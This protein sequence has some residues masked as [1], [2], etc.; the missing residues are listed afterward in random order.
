MICPHCGFNSKDGAVF[1]DKCGK[2]MPNISDLFSGP[3]KSSEINQQSAT[4]NNTDVTKPNANFSPIINNNSTQ[5]SF[6]KSNLDSSTTISKSSAS[7]A[8]SST[9]N[10]N[11]NNKSLPKDEIKSDTKPS[12]FDSVIENANTVAGDTAKIHGKDITKKTEININ[13]NKGSDKKNKSLIGFSKVISTPEF[14]SKL[15]QYNLKNLM[16]GLFIIP[17]PLILLLIR[18]YLNPEYKITMAITYGIPLSGLIAFFLFIIFLKKIFGKPWEGVITY[19]DVEYRERSS[20]K[21]RTY[22]TYEV[23]VIRIRKDS[24]DSDSIEESSRNSY[25]YSHFNLGERLK[26]HPSIDYYEKYDKSKDKELLCPFCS[27]VTSIEKNQC[28]KCG[29]PLIK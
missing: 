3:D 8:P 9:L 27:A 18:S 26:F 24:G 10:I 2:E 6:N 11:P 4:T 14:K 29:A 17:I 12:Y 22:D 28:K 13:F 23:Y 20:N 1:C 15:K 21:G 16:I 5:T 25:Y 19:K 7:H